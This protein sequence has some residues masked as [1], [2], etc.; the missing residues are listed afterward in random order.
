MAN[1]QPIKISEDLKD[2]LLKV[3]K[4]TLK[5]LIK[6]PTLPLRSGSLWGQ[7]LLPTHQREHGK[8]K[9]QAVKMV[10]LGPASLATADLDKKA[11]RD[12]P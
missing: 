10:R 8:I 6:N 9:K 1:R 7:H 5:V 3:E 12:E 11:A 4:R 2:T